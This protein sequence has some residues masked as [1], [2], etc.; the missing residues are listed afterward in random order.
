MGYELVAHIER[1]SSLI[2]CCG[3]RVDNMFDG[4]TAIV[5]RG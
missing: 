2:V 1:S 3:C 4:V 5:C